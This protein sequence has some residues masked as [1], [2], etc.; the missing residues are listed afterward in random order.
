MAIDPVQPGGAAAAGRLLA[1]WLGVLCRWC[2][3][4]L[5]WLLV[6]RRL[7]HGAEPVLLPARGEGDD[8]DAEPEDRL[9]VDFS[10]VSAEGAYWP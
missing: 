3:P 7:E 1:K 9:P 6:D 8:D 10:M 4:S 5:Y 2:R